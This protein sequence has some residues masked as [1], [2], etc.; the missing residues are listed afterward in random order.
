M[1]NK[2][3]LKILTLM[4][5]PIYPNNERYYLF[6][7]AGNDL[8]LIGAENLVTADRLLYGTNIKPKKCQNFLFDA[9]KFERRADETYYFVPATYRN[10]LEFSVRDGLGYGEDDYDCFEEFAKIFKEWKLVRN[11]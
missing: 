8:F 1:S 4:H 11:F 3:H 9:S 10:P 5:D 7:D 2:L 6:R